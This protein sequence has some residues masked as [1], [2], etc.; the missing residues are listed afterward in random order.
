MKKQPKISSN[1]KTENEKI[2]KASDSDIAEL[3]E[4]EEEMFSQEDFE[5]AL[6]RVSRKISEP[7]EETT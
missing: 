5:Y 6:R 2:K 4:S 1:L 7:G 3:T